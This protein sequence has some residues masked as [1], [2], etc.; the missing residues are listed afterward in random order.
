MC[1]KSCC[2]LKFPPPPNPFFHANRG[3]L[4][5]RVY[6]QHRGACLP[7]SDGAAFPPRAT[8]VHWKRMIGFA[9]VLLPL[10]SGLT[11]P[12]GDPL[13]TPKGG[14]TLIVS[15]DHQLSPP[16]HSRGSSLRLN[17][18]SAPGGIPSD[19]DRAAY[20]T[21]AT[22][23]PWKQRGFKVLLLTYYWPNA[24][25]HHIR[26]GEGHMAVLAHMAALAG[27]S[28]SVTPRRS[29]VVTPQRWPYQP[30]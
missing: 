18:P 3:P 13:T 6:R 26:G 19:S 30:P 17:S 22:T 2:V 11:S 7:G 21:R 16:P 8:M 10:H 24:G 12:C 4:S 23:V 5:D 9:Q 25:V 14:L 27:S 15:S 20:P 28:G 29:L 1:L